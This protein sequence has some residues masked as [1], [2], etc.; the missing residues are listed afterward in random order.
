MQVDIKKENAGILASDIKIGECFWYYES[1]YMR[2][3][4]G[5]IS[6]ETLDHYPVAVIQLSTGSTNCF[7]AKAQVVIEPNLKIVRNQ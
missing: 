4:S 7:G 2:I 5:Y 3:S 6:K 1:L